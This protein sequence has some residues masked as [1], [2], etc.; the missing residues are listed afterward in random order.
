MQI[1]K[2]RLDLIEEPPGALALWRQ[3]A[4]ALVQAAMG[5]PR[6]G[7]HDVQVGQERV[8]RGGLRSDRRRRRVVG[9]AQHEP[10]VGQHELARGV[11]PSDV[12]VIEPPDLPRAES[13]GHE[14]LDEAHAVGGIGARQ[15]HEVLHRRM[16][17]QP[18]VVHVLLDGLGQRAHQTHAARHPAHTAIEPPRQRLQRQAM[19]LMQRAQQPA[20]LERAV[21]GIRAQQLPKDQRVGLR[22][23]PHDGGDGIPVQLA[24]TA[25]AF[26]PVDDDVRRSADHHHD[27]H[28]LAGVRQRGQ[29]PTFARRL[30]HAQPL[31]AQFELMKFQ[32]HIH[33]PRPRLWHRADRVLGEGSGKS[34]AKSRG[35][36][37]FT[38]PL[39]LR[40]SRGKSARFPN[41]L[42][43]LARLL[44]LHRPEQDSTE[45][46][47]KIGPHDAEGVLSQIP[48]QL[49]ERRREYQRQDP[50]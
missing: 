13:M 17:D 40:R 42:K 24:E 20:L 33:R 9:H 32:V 29:Q 46:A 37:D 19:I 44:V 2:I 18:A 34:A 28:L 6:D 50:G 31:V 16:R 21:G 43:H 49:R 25:D 35:V 4:A 7:P 10:R 22:H 38:G 3:E 11:D 47:E 8:G 27:R 12:R 15:G 23:L 1:A 45:V 48:G 39:V 5:P 41:G 14:R 36:N 26:V 30:A